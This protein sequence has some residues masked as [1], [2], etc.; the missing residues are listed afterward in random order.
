[1]EN[2]INVIDITKI[3]KKAFHISSLLDESDDK[4]YW[5]S[6]TPIERLIAT[7]MMRQINYGYNPVTTRLQRVLEVTELA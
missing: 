2:D 5:L 3:N 4:K 1:M 7:E 6:K